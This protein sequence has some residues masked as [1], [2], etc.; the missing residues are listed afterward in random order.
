[1]YFVL[2]VLRRNTWKLEARVA[3]VFTRMQPNSALCF[4]YFSSP[5]AR[6]FIV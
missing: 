2:Q 5:I 6:L 1:M 4:P 3:V